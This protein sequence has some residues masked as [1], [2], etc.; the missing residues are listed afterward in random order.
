MSE[1]NKSRSDN[2][3]EKELGALFERLR[4]ERPAYIT[5]LPG[6]GSS[7]IYYR[8]RDGEDFTAIGVDS[9]DLVENRTFCRLSEN[10]YPYTPKIYIHS[11]DYSSYLQEDLGN[12]RLFDLLKSE[13]GEGLVKRTMQELADLQTIEKELWE[14]DVMCRPFGKRQVLW[15]LNYFKYSFLKPCGVTFNEDLLEDDFD[16]FTADLI[17]RCINGIG[18]MYRDCQSRNVMFHNGK[19]RFIDFQ[20]GRSGPMLY[21]AISFLWQ[22][23]AGFPDTFRKRM[24]RVYV[25]RIC[26]RTGIGADLFLEPLDLLILFRTLQVLGAYGFRGLIEK[27]A[28]FI[29]SIPGAMDN[30]REILDKGIIKAYPELERVCRDVTEDERWMK[31]DE[32]GLTVKVFSFSYKKGYPEDLSGNGGGFMFDCRAIHNPGRNK[33]YKALTGRDEE[34]IRFLEDDGEILTFLENAYSLVEPAVKRYIK[35]GFN[36]L[37]IGFGCT[38]G[39]HRSVYCAQ[40]MAERL[41]RDFPDIKVRLDHREQGLKALYGINQD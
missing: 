38:G 29:E 31:E 37:Q 40:K 21:D 20:G 26:E 18:F 27:K 14:G 36:S 23:R 3:I 35:R 10:F 12:V 28:H 7:R 13:E 39:Q 33:V 24:L 22:A 1:E 32:P 5:R 9:R 25:S 17:A 2:K 4:G 41:H 34:V 30:L 11:T 16:N 19:I 6:A 8:L 15:D